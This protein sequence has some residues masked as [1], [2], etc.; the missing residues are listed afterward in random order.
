VDRIAREERPVPTAILD[1][2]IPARAAD[3]AAP[4]IPAVAPEEDLEEAPPEASG[5]GPETEPAEETKVCKRC[6]EK[7][8][9]SAY[10]KDVRT[11]DGLGRTCSD[12]KASSRQAAAARES[13]KGGSSHAERRKKGESTQEA[14]REKIREFAEQ[15]EAAEVTELRPKTPEAEERSCANG[16]SC[17]AVDPDDIVPTPAILDGA[18]PGPLCRRCQKMAGVT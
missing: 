5:S 8:P 2:G 1:P 15:I 9:L 6:G 17:T 18:N 4:E 11:A 3:R 7:K 13:R 16:T 10:G 12:C 14:E